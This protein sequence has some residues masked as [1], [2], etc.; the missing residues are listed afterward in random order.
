MKSAACAKIRNGR[1][2]RLNVTFLGRCTSHGIHSAECRDTSTR[3]F[4]FVIVSGLVDAATTA[5]P[6]S[7]LHQKRLHIDG[8]NHDADDTY[9]LTLD[10]SNIRFTRK[11]VG[12]SLRY[13]VDLY[14]YNYSSHFH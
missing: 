5:K 14:S 4:V 7:R 3:C 8:S 12:I 10:G 2:S 9:V 6:F 1:I 13:A 11:L